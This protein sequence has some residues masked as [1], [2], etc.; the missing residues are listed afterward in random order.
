MAEPIRSMAILKAHPGKE[1]ELLAF[2]REFY[3]MMYTKQYSRDM[4][5]QDL[6]QPGVLVHVR[7]WLSNE[8][9]R[10]AV[11]DPDV[12]RYWIK[13]PELGTI[14]DIHEELKPIFSTQELEDS[15]N[16]DSVHPA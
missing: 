9:R 16:G 15:L 13:L 1:P 3:S 2:L 10:S 12:H 6:K 11:N 7:I 8:A 5:F 4:L 14:I